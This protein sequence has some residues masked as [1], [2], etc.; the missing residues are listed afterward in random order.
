MGLGKLA[1][2]ISGPWAWSNLTKSKIDF[3]LSPIPGVDGNPGRPFVGV[4][5][6]YLNRS[7]PNQDVAKEFLERYAL[8][9]QGLITMDQAQPIGIPA[10]ITLYNNMATDSTLLRQL[11]ICVDYG[12]IMPN[13]PQMGR[14]FSSVGTALEIAFKEKDGFCM[15]IRTT[16]KSA[17]H[18]IPGKRANV[19]RGNGRFRYV[20]DSLLVTRKV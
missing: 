8:T 4:M 14:F 5:V 6:A 13:I 20:R 15:I 10:L 2:I 12:E 7:S 11:K 1:M 16:A 17:Y 9:Q 3:G 19:I 18:P